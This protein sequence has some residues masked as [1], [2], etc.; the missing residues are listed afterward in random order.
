MSFISLPFPNMCISI[1]QHYVQVEQQKLIYELYFGK[2]GTISYLLFADD[3]L[4]FTREVMEDYKHLK[5]IF[6]C[7]GKAS[8]L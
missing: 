5:A 6:K 8:M 7:Y 1:F 4:I 2:D 3:R